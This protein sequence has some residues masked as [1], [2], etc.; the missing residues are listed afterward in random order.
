M[1]LYRLGGG[2]GGAGDYDMRVC[3]DKSPKTDKRVPPRSVRLLAE[4]TGC[5][6]VASASLLVIKVCFCGLSF[7]RGLTRAD[8]MYSKETEHA[9]NKKERHGDRQLAEVIAY[10]VIIAFESPSNS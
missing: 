10:Y 7:L 9:R 8:N 1:H 4:S 5:Q 3:R 2:G 6:F